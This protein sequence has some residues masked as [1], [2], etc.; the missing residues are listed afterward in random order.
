MAK[1][2]QLVPKCRIGVAC[3]PVRMHGIFLANSECSWHGQSV[4]VYGGVAKMCMDFELEGCK[5]CKCDKNAIFHI[6]M[7]LK[8]S[9]SKTRDILANPP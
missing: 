2:V 6:F 4:P 7:H 5:A 1:T 9:Y 3:V 8:H